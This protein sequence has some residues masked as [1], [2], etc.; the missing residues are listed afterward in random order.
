MSDFD[1]QRVLDWHRARID[2]LPEDSHSAIA[3]KAYERGVNYD[4]I[5][6]ECPYSEDSDEH[7]YWRLGIS[8]RNMRRGDVRHKQI[9][10]MRLA[11]A[12]ERGTHTK[13]EWLDFCVEFDYRCVC[14]GEEAP[15]QLDHIVPLY[16][17]GSDSIENIQPLCK[18]C[19]SGKGA[20][21]TNWVVIRRAER[22][23]VA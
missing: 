4:C 7:Y 13:D 19:N 15:L 6:F 17:G 12:R 22:E 21:C 16:L 10:R 20:D 2:G 14:C 23:A 18:P 8:H 5:Y 1:Y 3:L 9:R 11:A